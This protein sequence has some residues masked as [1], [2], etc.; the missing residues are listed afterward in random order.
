MRIALN[1]I[2]INPVARHPLFHFKSR[3]T[4]QNKQCHRYYLTTLIQHAA[5]ATLQRHSGST[6]TVVCAACN[7]KVFFHA[8]AEFGPHK[9]AV[10]TIHPFIHSFIEAARQPA[11]HQMQISR[12]TGQP[13]RTPKLTTKSANGRRKV[14]RK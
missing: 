9:R 11:I 1:F 7:N 5:S 6:V 14:E 13:K 4:F 8:A 2:N 3:Y 10:T 12:F